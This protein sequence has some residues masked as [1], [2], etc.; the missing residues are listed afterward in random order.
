MRCYV[1]PLPGGRRATG[2]SDTR[3]GPGTSMTFRREPGAPALA[4]VAAEDVHAVNCVGPGGLVPPP[5]DGRG[6]AWADLLP[7][8]ALR[9]PKS[10]DLLMPSWTATAR[11]RKT[12]A[13]ARD[14][15]THHIIS[16]HVRMPCSRLI[17]AESHPRR[18][19]S[20]SKAFKSQSCGMKSAIHQEKCSHIC[21]SQ[22]P[23]RLAKPGSLV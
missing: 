1:A 15:A 22:S 17:S 20:T 4:V 11:E 5:R 13:G 23:H 21:L 6:A 8:V 12:A 3:L 18:P 10:P 2:R 7:R 9:G 16:A 19:A 14:L